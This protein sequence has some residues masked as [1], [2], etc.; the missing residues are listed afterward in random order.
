MKRKRIRRDIESYDRDRM[1]ELNWETGAIKKVRKER[2][3]LKQ[4][5]TKIINDEGK[6]MSNQIEIVKRS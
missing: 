3:R 2:G 6:G 5:V 4:M 1:T